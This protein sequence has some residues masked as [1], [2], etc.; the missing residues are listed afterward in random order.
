MTTYKEKL[1]SEAKLIFILTFSLRN[2]DILI[3]HFIILSYIFTNIGKTITKKVNGRIT[4]DIKEMNKTF[5]IGDKKLISLF[6][7]IIIGK[8]KTFENRDIKI[9]ELAN[10]CIELSRND[11]D[12]FETSYHFLKQSH[13]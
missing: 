11:W 1:E 9:S 6:I 5:T 3:K 7:F 4:V 12:S 8:T 10:N 2:I 13:P